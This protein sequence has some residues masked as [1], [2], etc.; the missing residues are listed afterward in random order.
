MALPRPY[1]PDTPQTGNSLR[2]VLFIRSKVVDR[3]YADF[4][5]SDKGEVR[6]NG[7]QEI[8]LARG[9]LL[10]AFEGLPKGT[11]PGFTTTNRRSG[12]HADGSQPRSSPMASS[13]SPTR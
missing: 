11:A 9:W 6:R 2:G 8:S 12:G 1:E 3:G 4:R 7:Y 10:S 13:R 5:E